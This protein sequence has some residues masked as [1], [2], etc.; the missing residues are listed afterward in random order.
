M[1]YN[2]PTMANIPLIPPMAEI[3]HHPATDIVPPTTNIADIPPTTDI[4]D[5]PPSACI[6]GLVGPRVVEYFKGLALTQ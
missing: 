1:T 6:P 5:V 4:A 3:H 2:P